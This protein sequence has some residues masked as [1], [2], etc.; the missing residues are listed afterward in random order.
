M[1]KSL[2]AIEDVAVQDW[3]TNS[4]ITVGKLERDYLALKETVNRIIAFLR[5]MEK[6]FATGE[7]IDKVNGV[8][9]YDAATALLKLYRSSAWEQIL[10]DGTTGNLAMPAG[11]GTG[12]GKWAR[13]IQ[14]NATEVQVVDA[15]GDL[16]SYTLPADTFNENGAYLKAA[17]W[18]IGGGTIVTV[19][20]KFGA[21]IYNR[22]ISGTFPAGF[23]CVIIIRTASGAQKWGHFG[24]LLFD[25][26][27][28]TNLSNSGTSAQTETSAII[29]KR[30]EDS[31]GVGDSVTQ[32][33]EV[34]EWL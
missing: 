5:D 22:T 7:P 19:S 1:P 2:L 15:P 24:R 4:P 33:G 17:A 29:F 16:M 10:T 27:G 20:T 31:L 26:G 21:Q 18:F 12:T 9:W 32:H 13:P 8:L 30:T 25:S 34:L 11:G 3:I 28:D 23:T 14:I 6:R